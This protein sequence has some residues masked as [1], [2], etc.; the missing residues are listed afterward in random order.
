MAKFKVVADVVPAK[1]DYLTAGKNYEADGDTDGGAEIFADDGGY[2]Y[3][4][5]PNCSHL[6]EMPWRIVVEDE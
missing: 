2:L 6:D 1:T 3:I 4:Y 5:I